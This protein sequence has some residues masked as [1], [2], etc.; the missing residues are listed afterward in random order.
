MITR[1]GLHIGGTNHRMKRSRLAGPVIDWSI[2]I[3]RLIHD[4]LMFNR[5]FG[6][7]GIQ[8]SARLGGS[9]V[10]TSH[11]TRNSKVNAKT[12]ISNKPG[13]Y[14]TFHNRFNDL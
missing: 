14:E 13:N 3:R 7:D 4:G 9:V 8:C 1:S 2:V 5:M 11:T 6:C 12:R 10:S